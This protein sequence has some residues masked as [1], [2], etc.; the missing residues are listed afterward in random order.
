M[1]DCPTTE[2]IKPDLINIRYGDHKRQVYDFW[3]NPQHSNAP[4]LIYIHGGGFMKGNKDTA[5][6]MHID[7]WLQDGFAFASIH[8]RLTDSAPFPAQ[9]H[10]AA[11]ALQHIRFHAQQ[12]GIDPTRIACAGESA[13]SGISQ[14]I[15]FHDDLADAN[16]TDPI[17]KESTR[18]K[19]IGALNMQCTY[20]PRIIREIVPGDA[21]Q[22]KAMKR[23]FNVGDEF[24]W[25]N[26]AISDEVDARMQACGPLSLLNDN[27]PPVFM[28][29]YLKNETAGNI[30]HPNLARHLASILDKHGLEY[31]CYL[32]TDFTDGDFYDGLRMFMRKHV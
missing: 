9:M 25:D 10:D 13:G 21:H 4:L 16:N 23:L 26:D 30:H 8:Y 20:D 19:A 11:R 5:Q 27:I 7:R 31:E 29:N 12:Y 2:I 28:C 22:H 32:D 3:K 18:I 1:N 24:N 17:A 6:R 15:G 14:W